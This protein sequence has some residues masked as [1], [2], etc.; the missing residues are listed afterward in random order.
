MFAWTSPVLARALGGGEG[1]KGK[2]SRRGEASGII[3]I[4]YHSLQYR[5]NI[6]MIVIIILIYIIIT[7]II[8][9]MILVI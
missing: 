7:I 8:I 3:V 2:G 5:T 1:P 9:I 6:V 4:N